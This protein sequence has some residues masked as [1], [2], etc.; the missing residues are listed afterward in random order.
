MPKIDSGG[1]NGRPVSGRWTPTRPVN[2]VTAGGG[3]RRG[4]GS[5]VGFHV[6]NRGVRSIR[7]AARTAHST[8][9]FTGRSSSARA[10]Q[11]A[12]PNVKKKRYRVGRLNETGEIQTGRGYRVAIASAI[13][14]IAAK[15]FS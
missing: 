3:S 5:N 6:R 4:A 11:T 2:A 1:K 14:A 12:A 8:Q 15:N 9:V 10:K 13:P 7:I